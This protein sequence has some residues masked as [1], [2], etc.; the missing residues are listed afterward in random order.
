ML[1][2][3][4]CFD[5]SNLNEMKNRSCDGPTVDKPNEADHCVVNLLAFQT[6]NHHKKPEL[7]YWLMEEQ[8]G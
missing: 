4:K 1:V 3:E 7:R 2:F 5:F 6:V 8:S